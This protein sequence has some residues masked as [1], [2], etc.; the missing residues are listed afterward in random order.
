MVLGT[1]LSQIIVI[2]LKGGE[3]PVDFGSYRLYISSGSV[4]QIVNSQ[5]GSSAKC[6]FAIWPTCQIYQ[7]NQFP[8]AC[9]KEYSLDIFMHI[10]LC[11][12]FE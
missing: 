4:Y 7:N 3:V 12:Y 11:I 2:V 9:F 1:F 8:K 5:R 10:F 6:Q